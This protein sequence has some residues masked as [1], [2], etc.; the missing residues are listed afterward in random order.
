MLKI[1]RRDA[2]FKM[3]V[4]KYLIRA[5]HATISMSW[6]LMERSADWVIGM[7][8]KSRYRRTGRC[9]SCGKCCRLL[10]ME[11]PGYIMRNK[12]LL[13]AVKSWHDHVL[14][15]EFQG[16]TNSW[17]IYRCRYLNDS[18]RCSIYHF[19]HKLC[20]FYP[21][22]SLYSHPAL[23]SGCGFGYKTYIL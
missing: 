4:L 7:N 16:Q 19:R 20:R 3:N 17:L 10:A 9:N 1:T 21:R 8:K 13:N 22:Q 12:I 14:N 6:Y 2:T 23:H 5:V 11:V 15:F 18:N